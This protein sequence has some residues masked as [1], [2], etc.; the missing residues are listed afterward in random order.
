LREQARNV[1]L[2]VDHLK[3]PHSG[4]RDAVNDDVLAD[5]EAPPAL[6]QIVP[7]ATEVGVRNMSTHLR[8]PEA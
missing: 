3:N 5:D 6:V 7:A 4:F 2:A 8:H 1:A